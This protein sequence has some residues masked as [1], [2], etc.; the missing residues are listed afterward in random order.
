MAVDGLDSTTE[1]RDLLRR[2]LRHRRGRYVAKRAGQLSGVPERTV[3]EWSLRRVLVPDFPRARP[4]LW[5]Y[6]DLVYLRL[7]VRLRERGMPREDASRRVG[8]VRAF[9]ASG[10]VDDSSVRISGDAV[11]LPG[12]SH[13]RLSGQGAFAELLGLTQTF[14]L[15]E[16][17]EGVSTRRLWGPDLLEPSCLTFIS[18]W[19]VGG[20]PCVQGT[21]VPT[22]AIRG[23]V[24]LRGLHK[25]DV[26]GL[27]P[28]LSPA[29]VDDALRLEDRLQRLPTAA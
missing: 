18:P 4:K 11:F 27:Y 1:R 28:G 19:V 16:P 6:R 17:V 26:L 29:G 15:L 9:F 22:S 21:R 8:L 23:L 2:A 25:E 5:S 14:D 3:Y 13:D 7:L 20:E 12:E 10:Q 24:K